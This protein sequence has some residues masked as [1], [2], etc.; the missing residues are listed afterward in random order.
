LPSS[1][2]VVIGGQV[3]P[4][5]QRYDDELDVTL[6]ML[7]GFGLGADEE[8]AFRFSLRDRDVGRRRVGANSD[9]LERRFEQWQPRRRNNR[10]HNRPRA[11]SA[12]DQG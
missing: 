9:E 8:S 7:R 4:L 6:R 10:Q 1:K 3:S 5:E 2:D 11:L 12:S